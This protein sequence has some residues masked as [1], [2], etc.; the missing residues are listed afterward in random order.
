ME[1]GMRK[2]NP[3]RQ[4]R[5]PKKRPVSVY[6]LTRREVVA[7]ME[8]ARTT[9]ERRVIFI[10]VLAG[11]RNQ[12]LRGLQRRHVERVEAIWVSCDIAKGGRERFVPVLAEL[13]PIVEDVLR[14]VGSS[15]YVI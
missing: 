7:L 11:L 3:A 4:T 9:R 5:R 13:E 12:E 15:D 8:A 10:G 14:T 2:D 1:E 6:R